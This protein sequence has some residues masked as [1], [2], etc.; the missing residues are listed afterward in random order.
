[1]SSLSAWRVTANA[2]RCSFSLE[3]C[4]SCQLANARLYATTNG[5]RLLNTAMR[6]PTHKEQVGGTA[7]SIGDCYVWAEIYYLDSPTDYRECLSSSGPT[8]VDL[9]NELVMLD[10]VTPVPRV[11][12]T[13]ILVGILCACIILA[14]MMQD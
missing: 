14:T 2:R 5:A 10:D 7:A 12:S 1:M 8:P 9:S 13:K 4:K 3:S 11:L 6:E